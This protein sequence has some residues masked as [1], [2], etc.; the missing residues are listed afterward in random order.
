MRGRREEELTSHSPAENGLGTAIR[1]WRHFRGM[2][3]TELAIAAGF[4]KNGRGYIS[5]IEHSQIRHLGEEPLASI[6]Q[7]LNLSQGDLQQGRLPEMQEEPVLDKGT[8]DDAIA[9]C[10]AWLRVYRQD[11]KL[12]DCARTYFKLAELYW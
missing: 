4:G 3:V 9:G 2:T 6:A 5:K 10:K 7:A 1:A 8:L 11:D 12:L